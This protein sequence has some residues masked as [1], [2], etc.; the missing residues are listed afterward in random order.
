MSDQERREGTNTPGA[1]DKPKRFH[2]PDCHHTPERE[3]EMAKTGARCRC[4]CA[5]PQP[6]EGERAI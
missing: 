3:A 4:F 2:L 5:C 6:K 1:G